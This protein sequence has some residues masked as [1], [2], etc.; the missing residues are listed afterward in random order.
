[1]NKEQVYDDYI[2]PLMARILEICKREKIAMLAS[3]AIPNKDHPD[4]VCTSALIGP[5]FGSPQVF[6]DCYN[7]IRGNRPFMM[8]NTHD[9]D[10]KIIRSEAIL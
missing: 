7:A 6:R 3:F 9:K 5:E 8:T 4:L 10:G 2:S 1:M